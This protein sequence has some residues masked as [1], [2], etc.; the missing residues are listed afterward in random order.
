MASAV[1]PPRQ[2]APTVG[3]AAALASVFIRT[4]SIIASGERVVSG[5]V[6]RLGTLNFICDNA[7]YFGS[8]PM[9]RNGCLV[10]FGTFEIYV[11]TEF[12]CKYPEQVLV[13]EDSPAVCAARGRRITRPVSCA[14]VMMTGCA[15]ENPAKEMPAILP[16]R[17][18]DLLKCRWRG[19]RT[20]VTRPV[21]PRYRLGRLISRI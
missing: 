16:P 8:R 14:E 10:L 17:P 19:G 13:A 20:S 2:L 7:C 1:I 11:A 5:L 4:G 9:P 3:L 21:H 6:H 12:V 18:P 15:E